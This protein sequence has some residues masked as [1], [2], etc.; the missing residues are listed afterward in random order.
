MTFL[1]TFKDP[2]EEKAPPKNI[3]AFDDDFDFE[4][5]LVAYD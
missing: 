1:R 5:N 2:D 3:W 4:D